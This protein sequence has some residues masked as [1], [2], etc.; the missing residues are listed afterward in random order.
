MIITEE[1]LLL[2]KR[3]G[4]LTESQYKKSLGIVQLIN[5]FLLLENESSA[6]PVDDLVKKVASTGANIKDE[7][8]QLD[9]LDKFIDSNFQPEKID[10]KQIKEFKKSVSESTGG[11]AAGIEALETAEVAEEIAHILHVDVSVIKKASSVL[12]KIAEWPAEQIQK[13]FYKLARLFGISIETAEKVGL[14]GL[15][16][17]SLI[18]V[19]YGITHFPGL[20]A[21]LS[22]GFGIISLVKLGWAL[23]KSAAGIK[24]LYKKFKEWKSGIDKT[25]KTVYTTSKF[26][27]DIEPIYKKLKDGDK[28]PTNW[29]FSLKKWYNNI[30]DKEKI[31][32]WMEEIADDIKQN[33]KS[34]NI[35]DLIRASENDK[36]VLKIFQDI[37]TIFKLRR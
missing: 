5:E 11:L 16:I 30:N 29:V 24:G 32:N 18:C 35:E 10:P 7:D 22:G 3:A 20:I 27:T 14:G 4:I 12:K 13:F 28:I 6:P 9:I 21:S 25:G 15:T 2:Q 1:I 34:Y 31:S 19:I 17:I 23:V 37:K 36:E 8:I 26:L 33:K